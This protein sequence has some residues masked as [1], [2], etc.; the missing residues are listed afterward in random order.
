[1]FRQ[2]R[3]YSPSSVANSAVAAA[4]AR[5]TR[6]FDPDCNVPACGCDYVQDLARPLAA[7][8]KVLSIASRDDPIVPSQAT[9]VAHGENVTVA[10]SH[11]GLA[12]NK[13]VFEHLGRFLATS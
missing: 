6:L 4:G 2:S 7:T 3:T 11:G 5:A 10:G 1:M 8:T 12:H 9:Q 13:A